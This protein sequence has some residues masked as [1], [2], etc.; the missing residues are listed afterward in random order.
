[1]NLGQFISILRARWWVA[2]L[3]FVLT[4]G[5]TLVVSLLLPKQY[6]AA[7]VGGDRRQARP[8][9]AGRLPA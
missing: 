5:T 8:G 7:A 3:V 9:V 6:T 2:V 1:M 4:V